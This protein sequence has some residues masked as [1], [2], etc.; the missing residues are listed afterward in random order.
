MSHEMRTPLNGIAGVAELLNTTTLT[1]QQADLVR[2]LRHSVKVLKSLVDDVLDISKI[3]AGRLTVEVVS[4]DIHK[5]VSDLVDLLRSGAESKGLDLSSSIDPR[6]DYNLRGDPHHL[7]QVLLN[8]MG[9]AVKFTDTGHVRLGIK[10]VHEAADALTLRFEVEDSGI[11][12]SPDAVQR[13]F[14]RFVQADQSTTRRFGGTGLGTTI[15]KQLVEHMGG[16]IGVESEL[17]KGSTF[18]FELPVARDLASDADAREEGIALVIAPTEIVGKAVGFVEKAVARIR[19]VEHDLDIESAISAARRCGDHICAV[20]VFRDVERAERVF[21]LAQRLLSNTPALVY[22]ALDGD[23][24]QDT[25]ACLRKWTSAVLGHDA[26]PRYLRNAIH[27]VAVKE[28]KLHEPTGT[29]TQALDR[30]RSTGRILVADD[31]LTNQAIVREL[32]VRAGHEV[33]LASD[34]EEALDVF[35]SSRPDLALLDFNMPL[36]TGCEVIQAIRVLESPEEHTPAIILSASVTPESRDR[37]LRAGADGFVGKP[38]E[39]SKLLGE[40]DRL[41]DGKPTPP[42]AFDSEQASIALPLAQDGDVVDWR[43]VQE[44]EQ[45]AKSQYFMTDLLCGFRD[46]TERLLVELQMNAENGDRPAMADAAHAL[47]G[48]AVGVGARALGHECKTLED[49]IKSD[50]TA[51]DDLVRAARE[52]RSTYE[53]TLSA[54]NRYLVG[55]Q[56]ALRASETAT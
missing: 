45:L 32:L 8:L 39:A 46:D 26:C 7:R 53:T 18:W 2:L 29:L 36:R 3:E 21:A 4:F 13:I 23:A 49:A 38:F 9:N 56:K 48:A 12:I 37:A 28:A 27:A 11:G 44:L 25:T 30:R 15:A 17:G 10:K 51:P 16:T 47:K 43:R 33:L 19:V 1:H 55:S 6:I 22:L 31:N 35:E 40:I 24:R 20:V 54:L 50:V 14:E 52:I 42:R 34:G 41:L 5:L